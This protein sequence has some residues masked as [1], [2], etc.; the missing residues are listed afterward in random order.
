MAR[1][2]SDSAKYAQWAKLASGPLAALLILFLPFELKTEAHRL[3]AVLTWVVCWWVLEPVPLAATA[4]LAPGLAVFAGVTDAKSALAP[5]SHPLI[6]LFFG[7]FMIAKAMEVHGLDRRI[8]LTI[9]TRP[10]I[11]GEIWRSAGALFVISGTLSMWLSNTAT[12]AMLL[13][14]SMGIVAAL[15]GAKKD[16]QSTIVLGTAYAS[17]IGGLATPVGSPPNI[18]AVGMLDQ[19]AGK[20]ITFLEWMFFSVPIMAGCLAI[21]I[22]LTLRKLPQGKGERSL[23]FLKKDLKAMGKMA[24]GETS[25]MIAGAFAVVFWVGPGLVA[26]SLGKQHSTFLF[27]KNQMPEPIVALLAALL[28]FVLPGG[29][30]R[31][32]LEWKEAVKID[33]GALLLFGGGLSLGTM[34]FKTG[35]AESLGT[36]LMANAGGSPT[37]FLIIAVYFAIFMTELTSNTATAN[38]LVPLIIGGAQGLGWSPVLPTLGVALACSL[39]FMLPVATPPN[40]IVF[41]SGLIRIKQMIRAGFVLNLLTGAVVIVGLLAARALGFAG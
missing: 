11:R 19:L 24:P 22:A 13:P 38:L 5:F 12:T 32:A 3:A 8:A 34:M 40:A 35:L 30:S 7:G 1:A 20:T 9:L 36:V 16:H 4:L 31:R 15:F 17:S 28:L 21:L 6:Y 23:S 33:W 10:F 41:G 27:F 39:A 25:A 37:L 14:I 26:L 2:A 29:K 18:I